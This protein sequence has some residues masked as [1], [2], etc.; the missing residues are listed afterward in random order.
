M[1]EAH[2]SSFNWEWGSSDWL[3]SLARTKSP[4]SATMSSSVYDILQSSLSVFITAGCKGDHVAAGSLP[5]MQRGSQW[6]VCVC[7]CV[8]EMHTSMGMVVELTCAVEGHLQLGS[9]LSSQ[10]AFTA[11]Q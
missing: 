1:Y 4:F 7:V 5:H 10:V 6:G 8:C 2:Y 11:V 9:T 3:R